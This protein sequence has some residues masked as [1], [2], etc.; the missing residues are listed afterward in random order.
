MLVNNPRVFDIGCYYLI[1]TLDST[2]LK[3]ITLLL[4]INELPLIIYD[5]TYSR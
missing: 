5:N 1:G 4:S 3:L 2:E